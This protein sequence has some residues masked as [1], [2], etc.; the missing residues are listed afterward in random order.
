[1]HDFTQTDTVNI[2]KYQSG[3]VRKTAENSIIV[4]LGKKLELVGDTQCDLF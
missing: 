1:V 2:A 3:P 4:K